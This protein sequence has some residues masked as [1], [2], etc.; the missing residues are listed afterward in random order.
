MFSSPFQVENKPIDI[1]SCDI[2]FV[3]DIFADEYPGGAELTTAALIGSGGSTKIAKVKSSQLTMEL[4]STGVD[5]YWIFTNF[6]G[7]NK[8]LIPAIIANL[9]YSI[10]EYD[11]KY[12]NYR[13]P[14]KHE[15]D[16]GN[17]CDCHDQMIGKMIS[18]F[19]FGAESLFWMS[20]KQ[21]QIYESHFPFL[22]QKRSI[23][24]SSIF[25]P[26]FFETVSG[27][28]DAEKGEEYIIVGSNS[29]IKGVEDSVAYCEKNNLKYSVVANLTH[30]K[31]LEK[32]SAAKGLVFLPL[33]G[34]TCPRTVIEAKLLG[35]EL[36][37]ND[38]VLHKDE[39]WFVSDSARDTVEW[40]MSGPSRFWEEVTRSLNKQP[41]LSGYTTTRN[42]IDQ[43]Y[44]FE[45]SISSMLGFC[46]Q[47]IVV[48]G[49]STDGTIERL[50]SMA[51]NDDR[52]IV[53]IQKRDWESER[54]AVFDGLQKALARALCTSEFCWQQDSD[55][56]VH[57]R[58]YLK[59]KDLVKRLPK[60]MNLIALPVL[61]FWGGR[62]KVRIDITPWKWRLSRNQPHITHGIPSQLRVF[63]DEGR[64][65]SKPGS[66][67]CDYI[68]S[69]TYESIPFVNFYSDDIH[70]L[71][72]SALSGNNES[73]SSYGNWMQNICDSL[74]S[75][76]HY[77]WY[78]I[79]RKIKTYRN[80]WSRHWQSLYD[81]QQEDTA[82]NNMFFDK[83]WKDV[84]D[85]EI[86][87]L[88]DKLESELGGWIFH[89]KVDF[90]RPT[91]WL[92]VND[93]IH[94]DSMGN[95]IK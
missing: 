30:Q 23:L 86:D 67:G 83:S 62:G 81:I 8:E 87:T 64:L 6:A 18:A 90:S 68:R 94:P 33:G 26:K 9:R 7:M 59:I 29:W 47:V 88:A 45:Q 46:D 89:S 56:V 2:V 24:L 5:K 3:S 17:K 65:Y 20:D 38:N 13:S 19:F 57:D 77:S 43:L 92:S 41:T 11:F 27:L 69:D 31:L 91:P 74:P 66:D 28:I 44:P 4:L 82:E 63:D 85:K 55:E 58:D 51:E 39:E 10:V 35:C 25:S 78:D 52:L 84:D 71:R 14:E 95:W 34:D 22:S 50:M 53:H 36:I 40:L 12:C 79:K 48:D 16:T 54:F 60:S 61:E 15:A 80:Y 37:I 42:C 21:R 70:K 73:L 76:I 72:E 32:M 1:T 49:G 93:E 75:V